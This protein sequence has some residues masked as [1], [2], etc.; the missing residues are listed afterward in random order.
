MH[1]SILKCTNLLI[2][3]LELGRLSLVRLVGSYQIWS[4]RNG[5]SIGATLLIKLL[6][7]WIA[8]K[9]REHIAPDTNNQNY[10]ITFVSFIAIFD[11]YVSGQ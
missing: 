9:L 2:L 7:I 11:E 6:K 4:E 5:V 3:N 1:G 8:F 10:F